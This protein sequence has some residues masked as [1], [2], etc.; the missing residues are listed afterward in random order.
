MDTI[1]DA[2]LDLDEDVLAE[3]RSP[4]Q[5]MDIVGDKDIRLA[6]RRNR[7]A[8]AKGQSTLVHGENG[9]I[10]YDVPLTCAVHSDPRCRFRWSRL[11]IDLTSTPDARIS[12]MV[13]REVVDDR[14]IELTTT[15]GVGLKFHVVPNVL[16]A[17]LTPQ[18]SQ[19]RTVY[20]PQ[21]VS[22]GT[23]FT[24]GYWDFLALDKGYLHADRDL[25]LLV[26][27]PADTPVTV[28][29]QLRAKVRMAGVAGVI[30]LLARSGA[31][32]GEHRLDATNSK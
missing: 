13:P 1:I 23:G 16:S 22:S 32:D 9:L 3:E 2:Q 6:L 30:P 24:R 20:Y 17:D 28:R 27:A 25:R 18:Y 21:I 11:L 12:D 19:K 31:I 5:V 29:F 7:I 14:P 4:T 8:L 26:S 10:G 15:I